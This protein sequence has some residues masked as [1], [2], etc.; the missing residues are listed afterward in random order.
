MSLEK[1]SSRLPHNLDEKSADRKSNRYITTPKKDITK[2][3]Y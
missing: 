3:E 2:I 1:K